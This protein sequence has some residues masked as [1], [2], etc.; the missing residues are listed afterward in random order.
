M[1]VNEI[2]TQSK[3]KPIEPKKPLSPVQTQV[4]ALRDQSKQLQAQA[5]RIAAQEKI[6]AA[7]KKIALSTQQ[8]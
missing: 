6:R 4:K 5:K 8:Q 1:K 3:I 7:Q 2:T